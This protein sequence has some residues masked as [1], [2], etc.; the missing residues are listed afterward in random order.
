MATLMAVSA[1]SLQASAGV[2]Y[3]T[4]ESISGVATGDINGNS[5][6]GGFWSL[7]F[8]IDDT[9]VDANPSDTNLGTFNGSIESG[10]LW[11]NGE[12]Y[13]L[14]GDSAIGGITMSTS[15]SFDQIQLDFWNLNRGQFTTGSGGIFPAIASDINDLSSINTEVFVNDNSYL[16][17]SFDFRINT[18]Y[19]TSYGGFTTLSGDLI[20]LFDD[21]DSSTGSFYIGFSDQSRVASVPA[22][23]TGLL[24]ATG[25]LGLVGVS[26]RKKNRRSLSIGKI[27][28]H[29][30]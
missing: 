9:F 13:T 18:D 1:I 15:S 2:I 29:F 27:K 21:A 3:M 30:S 8:A 22:P 25:L 24:M 23:G 19:A 4:V 17:S 10:H 20:S 5:F 11:L 16:S 7:E 6:N 14:T 26:K 12:M 28:R